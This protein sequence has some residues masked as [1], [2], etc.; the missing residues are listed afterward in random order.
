MCYLIILNRQQQARPHRWG[1][2][3]LL[4]PGHY[5]GVQRNQR[6]L[7]PHHVQ[8]AS[9]F[10]QVRTTFK[11]PPSVLRPFLMVENADWTLSL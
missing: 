9:G 1:S 2:E 7:L 10:R 8:D 3:L 11:R 6:S 4:L 5:E